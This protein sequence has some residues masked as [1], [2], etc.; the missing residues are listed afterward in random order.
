MEL[1]LLDE[2]IDLGERGIMLIC[3]EGEPAAGMTVRDAHGNLHQVAEV[4]EQDGL[5]MMHLPEGKAAY[6]ERLFRDVRVDAARLEVAEAC[7]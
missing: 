7:R 2:V 4:S 6:F 5:W 3:L 1:R